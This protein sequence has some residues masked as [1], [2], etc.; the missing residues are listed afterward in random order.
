MMSPNRSHA[1]NLLLIDP[2]LDGW[3]ADPKLQGCVLQLQQ[4][5]RIPFA[6]FLCHAIE[7]LP[8]RVDAVNA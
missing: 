8:S 6:F 1:A 3:E 5:L 4:I 7:I 2:L